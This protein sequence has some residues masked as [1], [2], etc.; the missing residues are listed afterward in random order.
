MS[1]IAAIS[2]AKRQ[3]SG[4]SLKIKFKSL[5]ELEK[6]TPHK[7]VDWL[8]GET[9]NISSTWKKR[10][11]FQSYGN[12]LGAKRVK[13]EK[14][15]ALNKALRKWLLILRIEN[16]L[17]NESLFKEKVLEFTNELN[18]EGLQASE[19]WLKKWKK[20]KKCIYIW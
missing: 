13:P 5:K 11:I 16:V 15:E 20:K 9:K 6:G 19:E 3:H 10:K 1:D 7:D 8:F 4:K 12:G 18:I 2:A 17:V 14:Y